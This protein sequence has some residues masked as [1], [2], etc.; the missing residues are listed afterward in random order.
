VQS[1]FAGH[2]P[3]PGTLADGD[4]LVALA[5]A[6]EFEVPAPHEL[7]EAARS[8]KA[9]ERSAK[10]N[11]EPR[12]VPGAGTLRVAVTTDIFAGGGTV[13]FDE[14]IAELRPA[15]SATV[16]PKTAAALG[17]EAGDTV[18]VVSG[19]CAVRDLRVRIQDGVGDGVVSLVDGVPSAP[20]N[21]LETGDV[22]EVA[23]VRKARAA[24]AAGAS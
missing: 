9:P 14:R 10:P 18:D 5:A 20:A 4:M 12:P 15:G 13:W 8:P 2:A 21:A 23:N 22:A 19:D 7:A 1:L 24:A 17:L 3:P 11:A 16:N 6:L